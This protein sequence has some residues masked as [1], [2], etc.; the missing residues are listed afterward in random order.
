MLGRAVV[1]RHSN[2]HSAQSTTS[3]HSMHGDGLTAAGA[4]CVVH[5][6]VIYVTSLEAVGHVD[7][8]DRA[9]RRW[10]NELDSRVH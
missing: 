1:A 2:S 10:C 6:H 9:R 7:R 8:R 5:R 3:P 4:V